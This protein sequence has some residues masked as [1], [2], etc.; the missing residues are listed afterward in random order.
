MEL[1]R[2]DVVFSRIS[3]VLFLCRNK[4]SRNV[5]KIYGEFFWNKRKIPAQRST[6]GGV[7]VGHKPRG[8][9]HPL[10]SR[11]AGLWGPRGTTAPKLSSISS[12]SPG[13]NQRAGFITFYD[14]EAPPPRVL[15]L[16]GRSGVRFGLRRGEIVAIININLSPSPIP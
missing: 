5:L 10:W 8:R 12:V 2:T 9:G 15:H 14:T 6:G 11:H 1:T 7:S 3:M 16:E 13:K 4:S